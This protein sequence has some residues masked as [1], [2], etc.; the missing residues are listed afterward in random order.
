MAGMVVLI[1]WPSVIY[2]R[3]TCHTPYQP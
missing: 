3:F 2:G 1:L